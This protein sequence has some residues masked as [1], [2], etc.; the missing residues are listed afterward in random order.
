MSFKYFVCSLVKFK[1][2]IFLLEILGRSLS[3]GLIKGDPWSSIFK[4]ISKS[5]CLRGFKEKTERDLF[6]L[7]LFF[8]VLIVIFFIEWYVF[9]DVSN[10]GYPESYGLSKFHCGLLI[11]WLEIVFEDGIWWTIEESK[12]ISRLGALSMDYFKFYGEL[13]VSLASPVLS[14]SGNLSKSKGVKTDSYC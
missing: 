11:K 12:F 14:E 6:F 7:A 9:M 8:G 1:Y 10:Y 4:G 3:V 2:E 13:Q 5:E